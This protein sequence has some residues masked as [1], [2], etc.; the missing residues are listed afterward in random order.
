MVNLQTHRLLF[1]LLWWALLFPAFAH[2]SS[3]AITS[4]SIRFHNGWWEVTPVFLWQIDPPVI[5]A[6]HSGVALRF[7]LKGRL[8]QQAPLWW[9]KIL[10]NQNQNLE[11]R[12]FSLSKQYLLKNRNTG[13]QRSFLQLDNLWKHI[14]QLAPVRLPA[15][16]HANSVELRLR[17][18]T[19]ALPAAMQLPTLLDR[20]WHLDSGWRSFPLPPVQN[21]PRDA[22]KPLP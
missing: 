19:G 2:A 3:L 9:D 22:N 20:A 6:I 11:V 18:D 10:E 21:S 4:A 17:L 16:R 12:Y 8:I 15:H 13:Q 5:E 14:G 7:Q 1:L